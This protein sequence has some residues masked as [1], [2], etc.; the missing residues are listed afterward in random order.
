MTQPTVDQLP[1]DLQER[2]KQE[3]GS[4]DLSNL[5]AQG[6][7]EDPEAESMNTLLSEQLDALDQE[8]EAINVR[9]EYLIAVLEQVEGA[10]T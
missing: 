5:F 6:E 4:D 10:Q 9:C 8:V 1:E 2:I 3:L 7:V